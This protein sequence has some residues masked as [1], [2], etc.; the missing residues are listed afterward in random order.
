[1]ANFIG[2]LGGLIVLLTMGMTYAEYMHQL[3]SFITLTNFSVGMSKS[4]VFGLIVAATG[5]LRGMQC[6]NS[7]AAVGQATTRAVVTGITCMVLADAIFAAIF[8]T[9]RM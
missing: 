4:L 7:S 1:Y 3:T 2:I 9:L 5:C 8:N 6:G